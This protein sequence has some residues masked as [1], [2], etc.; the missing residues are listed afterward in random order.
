MKKTNTHLYTGKAA[1]LA[2]M[3]ELAYLGYNVASPEIDIGDDVFA[4]NDESG[5]AWRIQ[6]KSG[7]TTK[8]NKSVATTFSLREDQL[9]K[10]T[11]P[12]LYYIFVG[13]NGDTWRFVILQ[14]SVLKH[15]YEHDKLGSK[16]KNKQ[17][18]KDYINFRVVFHDDGRVICGGKDLQAYLN[19]WTTI[20]KN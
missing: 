4:I 9:L 11:T 2:V 20:P 19:K 5:N 18:K 10:A 6:V 3:A 14:R 12:E 16:F 13:R 8:Q 15:L 1:H 7:K 17:A